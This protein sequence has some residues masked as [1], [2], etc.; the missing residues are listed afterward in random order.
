MKMYPIAAI[1]AFSALTIVACHKKSTE[2]VILT[3]T[4]NLDVFEVRTAPVESST[5]AADIKVNGVLSSDLESKPSFKTGGVIQRTYYKEGDHVNQGAL[6]AILNMA[7]IKAQVEQAK[8]A[9][10]KTTRDLTRVTNLYKDSVATLEQTQNAQTAVDMANE[11]LKIALFNES[12]SKVIAPSSGIVVKQ[13]MREGEIVGPGMP[14]Y[15]IMGV[16]QSH[17]IIK[18]AVSD[19]DWARVKKGD[20]ATV[21]FEAWPNNPHDAMVSKLA[22][23]SNAG[24]GT[25]DIELKLS[26]PVDKLAAGLIANVIL[27]PKQSGAGKTTIPIEALVSSNQG[28][29]NIF[30]PQDGKAIKREII[31]DKILGDKV[32]VL[33]GLEGVKE[34][35]TSG[36]VYLQP[37]D[38]IKIN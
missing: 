1:I 2:A 17:W 29:A 14:I 3:D 31:I 36:A 27:K 13:L 35:I 12:Y 38:K 8:K 21:I 4:S 19:K 11:T 18:S 15:A 20:H 22:D 7:E 23:I 33:S 9:V 24:T 37:N 28:K 26:K 34:V 30:I 6:L 10:E 25:L 32:S 16:G 5:D